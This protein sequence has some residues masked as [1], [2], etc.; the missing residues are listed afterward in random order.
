[1]VVFFKFCLLDLFLISLLKEVIDDLLFFII[2]IVNC[3]LELDEFLVFLKYGFVIFLLRDFDFD[4]EVLE[5][6]CFIS[7]FLF[8]GKVIECIVVM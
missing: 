1:M 2:F 5:N 8:F 7:N 4:Y 3:L 6:Y